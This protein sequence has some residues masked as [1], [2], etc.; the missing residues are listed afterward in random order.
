MVWEYNYTYIYICVYV[1]A[2]MGVNHGDVNDVGISFTL[3]KSPG[4]RLGEIHGWGEP[5]RL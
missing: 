4:G 2:R 3:K 5:K 1:C